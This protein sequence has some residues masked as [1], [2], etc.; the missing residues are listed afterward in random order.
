MILWL[1]D[2]FEIHVEHAIFKELIKKQL[3]LILIEM[4]ALKPLHFY[5]AR[6]NTG[7]PY[8]SYTTVYD[9]I[10][11]SF[12]TLYVTMIQLI[13]VQEAHGP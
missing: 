10:R 11:S 4:I 9:G 8:I 13:N 6:E 3:K 5:I 2:G 7:L 1:L 12:I